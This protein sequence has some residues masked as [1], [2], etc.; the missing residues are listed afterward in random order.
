M[1]FD[2]SNSQ[3]IAAASVFMDAL[4][5]EFVVANPGV[6]PKTQRLIDYDRKN[7]AVILRATK[8][9]LAA[10]LAVATSEAR[11]EA[12]KAHDKFKEPAAE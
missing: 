11:A 2:P 4:R 6:I 7:Q 5:Q 1:S 12:A 8:R 10:A 9:M 3:V